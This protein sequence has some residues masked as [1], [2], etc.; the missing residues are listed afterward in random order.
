[1]VNT[2]GYDVKSHQVN[3]IIV[4]CKGVQPELLR[5]LTT[6]GRYFGIADMYFIQI[7]FIK[8]KEGIQP[9][10]PEAS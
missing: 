5:K 3:I 2:K 10:I 7:Q 8:L 1:M 9:N 6:H 4:S